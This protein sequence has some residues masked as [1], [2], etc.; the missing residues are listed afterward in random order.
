MIS[1]ETGPGF[2]MERWLSGGGG[3]GG[4]GLRGRGSFRACDISTVLFHKSRK[5]NPT[6]SANIHAS[7]GRPRPMLKLSCRVFYARNRRAIARYLCATL[8]GSGKE[9]ELF[10]YYF[11]LLYC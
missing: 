3:G 2:R 5:Q 7:L 1:N 4:V 8:R 6:G 9:E 10:Y 11:P